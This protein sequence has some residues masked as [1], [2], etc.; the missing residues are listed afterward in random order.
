MHEAPVTD[1]WGGG[2]CTE[3]S[4]YTWYSVYIFSIYMVFVHGEKFRTSLSNP[5]TVC[6]LMRPRGGLIRGFLMMILSGPTRPD[7][8]V[9]TD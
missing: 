5:K 2:G 6:A 1:L 8:L 9:R 3:Y 7:T 4:V